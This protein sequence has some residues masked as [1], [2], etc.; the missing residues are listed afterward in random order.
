V[1]DAGMS[2]IH[3]SPL[4]FK[5]KALQRFASDRGVIGNITV[6]SIMIVCVRRKRMNHLLSIS[7]HER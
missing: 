7:C 2:K 5:P 6:K 4:T 1:D 3:N